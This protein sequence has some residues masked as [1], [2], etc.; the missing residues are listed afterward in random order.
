MAE[1]I[2]GVSVQDRVPMRFYPTNGYEM[3]CGDGRSA[4]VFRD[5]AGG[6]AWLFNPWTGKMRDPRDIASDVYGLAIVPPDGCG[7]NNKAFMCRASILDLIHL[8]EKSTC[9][10]MSEADGE[11]AEQAIRRIREYLNMGVMPKQGE[12]RLIESPARVG[13]VV[14]GVGTPERFVVESSVR[15]YHMVKENSPKTNS[16]WA[17]F[18]RVSAAADGIRERIDKALDDVYNMVGTEA[19]GMLEDEFLSILDGTWP[20]KHVQEL[21]RQEAE[22]EFAGGPK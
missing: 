19:L 1:T 21:H 8:V 20:P 12:E 6:L 15:A 3:A 7:E 16:N 22:A 18:L 13:T 4:S 11:Y 14:F 5:N 9:R 17:N 2:N 10:F